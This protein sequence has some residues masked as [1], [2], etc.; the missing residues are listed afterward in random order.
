MTAPT[1][2]PVAPPTDAEWYQRAVFRA[3]L[4]P[5]TFFPI[6][7]RR[8]SDRVLG[9]QR[10]PVR[11]DCPQVGP[12]INSKRIWGGLPEHERRNSLRTLLPAQ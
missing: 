6:P 4:D 2:G 9:C 10:C 8:Q 12:L 7:T 3:H 5:D 1:V 11:A